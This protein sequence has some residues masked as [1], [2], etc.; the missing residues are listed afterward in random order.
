MSPLEKG[1]V[2]QKTTCRDFLYDEDR[3]PSVVIWEQ[4]ED[5][6]RNT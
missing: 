6:A 5:F 2:S 3:V 4:S 1:K